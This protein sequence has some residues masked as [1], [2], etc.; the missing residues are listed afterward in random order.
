[1]LTGIALFVSHTTIDVLDA[2]DVDDPRLPNG[3]GR[4]AAQVSRHRHPR[5]LVEEDDLD[6]RHHADRDDHPTKHRR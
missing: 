1:M 3:G 2:S 5:R 4:L 6:D